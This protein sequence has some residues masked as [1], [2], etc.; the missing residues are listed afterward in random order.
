[1]KWNFF[2]RLC[3]A[4]SRVSLGAVWEGQVYHVSTCGY[5][6]SIKATR[7]AFPFD[8]KFELYSASFYIKSPCS[9]IEA[10]D[11]V[12]LTKCLEDY[13]QLEWPR[14]ED[15]TRGRKWDFLNQRLEEWE[16]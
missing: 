3:N 8:G 13:W 7:K 11:K 6:L 15:K 10:G 1:M 12:L 2:Y 16:F 9:E 14:P 4:E 5:Y